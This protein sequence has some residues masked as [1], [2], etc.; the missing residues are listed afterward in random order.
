MNTTE[1]SPGDRGALLTEREQQV[2]ALM[3]EGCSNRL[4]AARLFV[5]ERTVEAHVRAIF[6]HL[7]LPPEATTNRRVAAVLTYIGRTPHHDV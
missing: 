6:L 7:G 5:S 2:L 4:I 3:A 1:L